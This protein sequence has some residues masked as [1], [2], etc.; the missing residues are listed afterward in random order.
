MF[1]KAYKTQYTIMAL[2]ILMSIH[3]DPVL[4]FKIYSAANKNYPDYND[5]FDKISF[6]VID[7]LIDYIEKV[8]N[9][10]T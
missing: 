9:N 5:Y 8:E 7:A 6:L 4:F 2:K 10:K 1:F 3:E